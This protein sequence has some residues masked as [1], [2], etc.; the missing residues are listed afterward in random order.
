MPLVYQIPDKVIG[1][2]EDKKVNQA[3]LVK[4]LREILKREKREFKTL[5]DE[6]AF[7]MKRLVTAIKLSP[8]ASIMLLNDY[9]SKL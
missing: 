3:K 2:K 7:K 9:N 6:V 1:V 5:D 4:K 8:D